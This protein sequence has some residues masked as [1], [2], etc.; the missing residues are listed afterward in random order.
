MDINPF[1]LRFDRSEIYPGLVMIRIK[2]TGNI[3]A[4]VHKHPY[5]GS[6]F[7]F[8]QDYVSEFYTTEQETIE[9]AVRHFLV[10]KLDKQ[11]EN[12]GLLNNE[13]YVKK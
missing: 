6:W 4:Y 8:I 3:I 2:D 5:E 12:A 10:V 9:A 11:Y 13:N 7:Y 1:N